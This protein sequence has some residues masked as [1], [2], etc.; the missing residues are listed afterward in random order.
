[1]LIANLQKR[2]YIKAN[3]SYSAGMADLDQQDK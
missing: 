2:L 3:G 1:M